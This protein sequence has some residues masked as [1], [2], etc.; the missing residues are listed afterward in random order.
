VAVAVQVAV[1]PVV[2][3]NFNFICIFIQKPFMY[4]F[5]DKICYFVLLALLFACSSNRSPKSSG[6]QGDTLVIN[7]QVYYLDSISYNEFDTI[8]AMSFNENE[9]EI[10]NDPSVTRT[11]KLVLNFKL[12]N[13]QQI[14]LQS[15]TT[16]S[17]NFVVYRYLETLPDLNYW[18]LRIDYYE[19]G[20]YALIDQ[21]NGEQI[22]ILGKPS[23][24]KTRQYAIASSFSPE[25]AYDAN[26][27]QLF[28]VENGK[29][30]LL[31]TKNLTD[32]SPSIVKWADENT[33]VM[34]KSQNSPE[35]N[36][37]LLLS[38]K[39]MKVINL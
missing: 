15:D 12:K 9:D 13:S 21:E 22:S 5:M 4:S 6:I 27:I 23:L 26:G 38:Y 8:P 2:N 16:E 19:G 10:I 36:A 20:E 14:V 28:K 30:K 34:E 18:L 29:L 17:E 33:I 37:D 24:N 32:W 3:G 31:W 25:G 35:S 39:K 11:S 7:N 1:V